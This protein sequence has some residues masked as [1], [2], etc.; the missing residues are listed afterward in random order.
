[1]RERYFGGPMADA[2]LP[3]QRADRRV[4]R[5]NAGELPYGDRARP[6]AIFPERRRDFGHYQADDRWLRAGPVIFGTC[7]CAL[8]AIGWFN[9][10]QEYLIPDD[11]AGYWLGVSGSVLMLLL[12]LY[13]LRKR[14]RFRGLGGSVTF[15]FRAHMILGLVGPAMILFHANFTMVTMNSAVATIAMLIVAASGIVGRYLYGK[16]HLG[17]YGR[18]AAV[19][20]MLA[21]VKAL[22]ESVGANVPGVNHFV[23]Q[24]HA[25]AAH[26]GEARQSLLFG[27]WSL[28]ALVLRARVA[29]WR[30]L[31]AARQFLAVEG[32]RQGWSKR[33]R[34]QR[35]AAIANLVTLYIS[36]T[37][38]AAAFKFYDRLFSIWHVLHVPL[39]IILIVAASVHVVAAHFY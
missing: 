17:L 8:L 15:W 18:K 23:D 28:L 33:E 38:K 25:F 16:I 36:A 14:V 3:Q 21:D 2:A 34:A 31:S 5:W 29:R 37:R 20:E 24:L 30:L 6:A 39:F 7:L 19:Q 10:D 27:A 12:L 1:M 9:R 35:F 11:G 32:E 13:P 26:L 4:R 22:K